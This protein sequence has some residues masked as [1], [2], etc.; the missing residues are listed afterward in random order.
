MP[1]V[2]APDVWYFAGISLQNDTLRVQTVDGYQAV[3]PMRGSGFVRSAIP[4]EMFRGKIHGARVLGL[5][6][7]LF[8]RAVPPDPLLI[9]TNLD[10][11]SKAFNTQYQTEQSL[12]QYHP[13]GTVRTA[14]AHCVGWNPKSTEDNTGAVY[15]GVAE[16]LMSD[17]YFY[18]PQ[19]GVSGQAA[20]TS[21]S[22]THPGTVRTH[23]VYVTF[24]G[25]SG[26][27]DPTITNNTNGTTFGLY[28]TWAGNHTAFIDCKAFSAVV[29]G[30]NVI[31]TLTHAG[32]FPFLVLEPGVNNLTVSAGFSTVDVAF[33][34]A[35]I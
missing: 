29:D 31:G 10:M 20:S 33:D 2:Y 9:H 24:H 18:V 26:L 19:I 34:P 25:P 30:G 8:S 28:G 7:T 6:L 15:K 21:F 5:G 17:P 22:I 16:F 11:L 35:Y 3:P 23:H 4:G 27:T 14:Q 1:S 32:D 12:T 13:D